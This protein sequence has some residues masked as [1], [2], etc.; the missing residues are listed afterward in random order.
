MKITFCVPS[1]L[2]EG[3]IAE[4]EVSA[5]MN[6]TMSHKFVTSVALQGG[7]LVA[8]YPLNKP[9]PQGLYESYWCKYCK[10]MCGRL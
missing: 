9:K 1:D 10:M 3:A 8:K 7:A 2:S 6:W 5:V 4:P